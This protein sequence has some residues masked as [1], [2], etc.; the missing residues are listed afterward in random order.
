MHASWH[1]DLPWTVSA[2]SHAC[3]VRKAHS[4][5]LIASLLAS[6]SAL[7]PMLLPLPPAGQLLVQLLLLLRCLHLQASRDE[8]LKQFWH[9]LKQSWHAHEQCWH[10]HEQCWHALAA[11]HAERSVRF[12]A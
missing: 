7:F 9:A 10:A 8:A 6:F 5:L 12:Q 3:A 1:L 4:H 11:T 2:A